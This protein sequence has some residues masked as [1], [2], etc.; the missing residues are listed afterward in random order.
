M[1]SCPLWFPS[2]EW[3]KQWRRAW[4]VPAATIRRMSRNLRWLVAAVCSAMLIAVFAAFESLG[5]GCG[6]GCGDAIN[7]DGGE[8]F[9][10]NTAAYVLMAAGFIAVAGLVA[11]AGWAA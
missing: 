2:H 8:S 9:E 10:C 1:R 6:C 3:G 5:A 7:A 4:W 11:I